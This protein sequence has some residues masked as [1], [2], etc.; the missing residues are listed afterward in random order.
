MGNQLSV[1]KPD[2]ALSF[3]SPL[4]DGVRVGFSLL[5]QIVLEHRNTAQKRD[6]VLAS[7]CI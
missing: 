7:S 5:Q 1:T 3:A 2:L 4:K 6:C